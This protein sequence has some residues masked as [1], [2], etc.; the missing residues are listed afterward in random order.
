MF[1][2]LTLSIYVCRVT[3]WM[4]D[5]RVRYIFL[6]I[7]AWL[8][9]SFRISRSSYQRCSVKKL[10]LKISQNSLE[11]TC[12]RVSFLNKRLWH[13]CFPVSFANILRTSFLQNTSE[14]LLL[15]FKCGFDICQGP[16][17]VSVCIELDKLHDQ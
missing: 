11:N 15:N 7:T 5:L 17:Y 1:L 9:W 8:S 14:R 12:A 16:K 2:L 13:R 10:F 3:L 4:K 6:D